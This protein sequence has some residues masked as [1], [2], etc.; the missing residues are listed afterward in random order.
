MAIANAG[1]SLDDET[2]FRQDF[3]IA[4]NVEGIRLE[5][6][7]SYAVHNG[8]WHLLQEVAFDSSS[9]VRTRQQVY[10]AAFLF[11]ECQAASLPAYRELG[12]T[13]GGHTLHHRTARPFPR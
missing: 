13:Q 9:V 12:G 3:E 5:D 1:V 4:L 11:E 10:R 8:A 7:V 6:A 2:R